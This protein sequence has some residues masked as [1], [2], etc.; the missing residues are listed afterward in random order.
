LEVAALDRV[1]DLGVCRKIERPGWV[2]QCESS[3]P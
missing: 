2:E 1:K 3:H